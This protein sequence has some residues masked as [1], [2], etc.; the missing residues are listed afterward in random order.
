MAR[1][2]ELALA[3]SARL[4]K[5]QIKKVA[6]KAASLITKENGKITKEEIWEKRPLAYPI[7]K[8]E[9]AVYLFLYFQTPSLS[10]HFQHQIKL[11]E[12]VL[13]FLLVKK[14]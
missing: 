2:Y 14:N 13:R 5:E 10:S 3:V 12:G 6:E 7:K 4:N 8:E 11:L 9:E 1:V